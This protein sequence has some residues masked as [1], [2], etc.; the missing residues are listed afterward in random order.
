MTQYAINSIGKD[1]LMVGLGC[2]AF[3]LGIFPYIVKRDS[4]I[5]VIYTDGRDS[6]L[7]GIGTSIIIYY[8]LRIFV[9]RELYKT[10][11]V[12]LIMSGILYFNNVYL[13][14]E[15]SYYQQLQVRDEIATNQHILNND[16]FIVIY[17]GAAVYSSFFQTNGNSW[18]AT[19]EQTR[20]YM[21]DLNDLGKFLDFDED[22]EWLKGFMM[23][24]FD[25]TDKTIDGVLYVNYPYTNRGLILKQKWNEFFHKDVFDQWIKDVKEMDYYPITPEQSDAIIEAYQNGILKVNH[26]IEYIQPEGE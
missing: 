15:N 16:S 10:V 19:G 4:D 22:S 11:L 26:L 2:I 6:L 9:R 3:Y 5:D 18:A 20:F 17:T 21:C 1:L 8:L 25:Y 14:W 13:A 12:F 23:R 7:L 24:D